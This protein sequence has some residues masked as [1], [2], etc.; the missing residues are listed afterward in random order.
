VR[1]FW[2]PPSLPSHPLRVQSPGFG[3]YMGQHIWQVVPEDLAP[4]QQPG[5]QTAAKASRAGW[6]QRL[7]GWAAT[8]LSQ[9]Q[10]GAP[11]FPVGLFLR[12]RRQATVL[13]PGDL[14]KFKN[15]HIY[16]ANGRQAQ[17]SPPSRPLRD[18]H[19]V[20]LTKDPSAFHA[21][22]HAMQHSHDPALD[23]RPQEGKQTRNN[24]SYLPKRRFR[25]AS[26]QW[27][28]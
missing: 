27:P 8:L 19:P 14:L 12:H 23:V 10:A 9:K 22:L 21:L 4:Q 13:R 25:A 1:A 5:P 2:L 17:G 28:G 18:W 16:W 3:K 15:G 6:L 7:A 20:S 24:V 11:A 26:Q